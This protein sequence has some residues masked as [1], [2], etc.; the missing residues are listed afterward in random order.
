MLD[1]TLPPSSAAGE[2]AATPSAPAAPVP[3]QR[4]GLILMNGSSLSTGP[5]ATAAEA[6]GG[7]PSF[8]DRVR[9]HRTTTASTTASIGDQQS[10]SSG[11][12]SGRS[13][14]LEA[15][16]P[17]MMRPGSLAAPLAPAAA[18]PPAAAP[19]PVAAPTP[20]PTAPA[21]RPPLTA[22]ERNKIAARIMRAKLKKDFATVAQLEAELAP[23]AQTKM[24]VSVSASG[25]RLGVTDHISAR[26]DRNNPNKLKRKL[27][28]H[29]AAGLRTRFLRAD[30]GAE[31]L[32]PQQ[33]LVREREAAKL[34]GMADVDAAF[35]E[36]VMAQGKR[37]S[38]ALGGDD[39]DDEYGTGEAWRMWESRK[40]SQ[41]SEKQARKARQAMV[42][43]TRKHDAALGA[44]TLCFGAAKMRKAAVIATADHMYLAAAAAPLVDGHVRIVPRNHE[45]SFRNTEAAAFAEAEAFM[46]ALTA[47]HA[48]AGRDVVFV[49]VALQLDALVHTAI[50]AVPLSRDDGAL[51]PMFFR[52]ALSECDTMW[53]SHER[54]IDVIARGGLQ[55]S[56]PQGF[57]YIFVQFGTS[58]AMAHAVEDQSL[59]QRSFG[60]EILAGMLDLPPTAWKRP[61]PRPPAAIAAAASEFA[62]RFADFDPTRLPP[63]AS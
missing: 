38:G 36:N 58:P 33:L 17:G 42:N 56:V 15:T 43:A 14:Y 34:Q 49:E 63:S 2:P 47:Y 25:A 9:A 16:R 18:P 45:V 28:T 11:A 22:A 10:D 24:L 40:A 55:K 23:P 41:S 31:D 39:E 8:R 19:A 13:R 59:F 62:D 61:H 3:Q 21:P 57:P 51:A 26:G 35:I 29:D 20:A 46:R 7:K 52:K 27:V 30:E 4:Y 32:T 44:C 53:T 5:P 48:A 6:P 12:S 60:L 54:V 37:Y 1:P 50:D